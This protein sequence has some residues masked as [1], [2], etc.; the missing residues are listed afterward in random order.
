MANDQQ[1]EPIV[2]ISG[3]GRTTK[4]GYSS[5]LQ[6][7]KKLDISKKLTV[8]PSYGKQKG[9]YSESVRGSGTSAG[10][11]AQY[12]V[13]KNV[14]LNAGAHTSKF[15]VKGSDWSSKSKGSSAN[16]GLTFTFK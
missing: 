14:T 4:K 1:E 8:T 16:V 12:K 7:S 13:N 2:N 11:N 9:K 5:N 6:V 15:K 3:S 10:V